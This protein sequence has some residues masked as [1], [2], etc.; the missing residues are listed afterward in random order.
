MSVTEND[1]TF[2][3]QKLLHLFIGDSSIVINEK[4]RDDLTPL[5]YLCSEEFVPV[6]I[7]QLLL[8]RGADVSVR[9]SQGRTCLRLCVRDLACKP[10][11][12]E[13]LSLLIEHGADVCA[14]DND[15]ISVSEVCYAQRDDVAV[16]GSYNYDVWDKV[17]CKFGYNLASFRT[18]FPRRSYYSYFYGRKDFE[19]LWEGQ[20]DLCPY[21]DKFYDI[22]TWYG[23]DGVENHDCQSESEIDERI[24]ALK[25]L[26]DDDEL[27]DDDPEEV[28]EFK[29]ASCRR[30]IRTTSSI[31][32]LLLSVVILQVCLQSIG[33]VLHLRSLSLTLYSTSL[34]GRVIEGKYL[35]YAEPTSSQAGFTLSCNRQSRHLLSRRVLSIFLAIFLHDSVQQCFCDVTNCPFGY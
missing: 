33:W 2:A 6:D 13:V 29:Q 10:L 16:Y 32:F 20:E 22:H 12:E 14:K 3:L 28:E 18:G 27:D 17:L 30:W 19:R 9:D 15:G 25:E 8:G 23:E 26:L 4:M 31:P 35:V 11:H 5:L 24:E 7:L 1:L 21:F 34:A